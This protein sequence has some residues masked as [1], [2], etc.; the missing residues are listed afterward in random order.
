MPTP[1][2]K[3][4]LNLLAVFCL[5]LSGAT[6]GDP[7]MTDPK[8]SLLDYPSPPTANPWEFEF[9][10]Y[11]WFA[12]LKGTVGV[13]G[14][15][16]DIDVGIDDI[17]DNLD[18]AFA[19]TA[20]ARYER[21][22]PWRTVDGVELAPDP[23]PKLQVLLDGLFEKRRFQHGVAQEGLL[24]DYFPEHPSEYRALYQSIFDGTASAHR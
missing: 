19:T 14:T 6:A 16:S 9:T 2:F 13:A 21:F 15:S 17:F 10:P 3:K 20:G 12:N 23:V 5:A 22:G 11:F 18:F 7:A 8:Q 4:L 24:K 1:T